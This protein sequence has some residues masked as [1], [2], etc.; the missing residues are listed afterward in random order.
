M[1]SNCLTLSLSL[2]LSCN[3]V[4]QTNK[5]QLWQRLLISYLWPHSLYNCTCPFYLS[6][7]SKSKVWNT[8]TCEKKRLGEVCCMRKKEFHGIMKNQNCG[9]DCQVE[10]LLFVSVYKES[11]RGSHSHFLAKIIKCDYL[12]SY[13]SI[14]NKPSEGLINQ[15]HVSLTDTWW[16]KECLIKKTCSL[17]LKCAPYKP[18]L[19]GT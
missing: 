10:R 9:K 15:V 13:F 8:E 3:S 4:V 7:N 14:S 16:I 17:N 2:K 6:W 11:W 5:P 19:S 1:L 18:I 12:T